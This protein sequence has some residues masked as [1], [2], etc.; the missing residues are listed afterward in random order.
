MAKDAATIESERKSHSNS[1]LTDKQLLLLPPLLS[2]PYVPRIP[3][4]AVAAVVALTAASVT[5]LLV[6]ES[7]GLDAKS[8]AD[9]T[10]ST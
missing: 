10:A 8:D 9:A 7:A 2:P 5:E 4:V 3:P 6:S 1:A